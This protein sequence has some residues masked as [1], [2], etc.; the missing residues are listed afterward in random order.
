MLN[1]EFLWNEFSRKGIPCCYN[2]PINPI[3]PWAMMSHLDI[4]SYG[5][6]WSTTNFGALIWRPMPNTFPKK[7][8]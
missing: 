1:L 6:A 3:I 2:Y 4:K 7:K 8:P 5:M